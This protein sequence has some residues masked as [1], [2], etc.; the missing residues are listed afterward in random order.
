VSS[1]GVDPRGAAAGA[2]IRALIGAATAAAKN[3][4]TEAVA[5]SPAGS[6]GRPHCVRGVSRNE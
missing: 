4:P 5:A 6:I 3:L 1:A 2:L